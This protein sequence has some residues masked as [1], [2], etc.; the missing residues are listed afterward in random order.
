[1]KKHLILSIILLIS[2]F[3]S[4]KAQVREILDAI[5]PAQ[6]F[7]GVPILKKKSQVI[8]ASI[9]FPNNTASLLNLGGLGNF[10][11]SYSSGFGP[12]GIAYEYL[13]KENLGLGLDVSYSK[14]TETYD[15]NISI[16]G[17]PISTGKT[18]TAKLQ[19]VSLLFSTNYHIYTTDK[20][21]TYVKG[22]IGAT[23]WS[24]SYK[25]ADGTDAGQLTL[26]TPLGYR[27]LVGIRY[28]VSDNVAPFG[29][30]SFSNL[31]FGA[32]IGVTYKMK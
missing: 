12:I 26:P 10:A 18:I 3:Y 4:A 17:F 7:S 14:A 29:E 2:I 23:L 16:A 30:L 20:Y 28:F 32:F 24:G 19:G 13:I 9:G 8:Q 21:D 25:N 1:M 5:K 6:A 27:A 22:A 31:K 11:K 15:G